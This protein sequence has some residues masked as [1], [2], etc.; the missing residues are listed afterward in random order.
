MAYNLLIAGSGQLGSRYLQGLEKVILPLNIWVSDPSSV[1]LKVAESRWREVTNSHSKHKVKFTRNLEEIPSY[2]DL[3]IVA[4]SADV[5]PM[6][7]GEISK[8]TLTKYWILEKVLGQSDRDLDTMFDCLSGSSA[9][10]VNTHFRTINF[11]NIIRKDLVAHK[12]LLM[13]VYGGSW[14]L[15]CNAIH[16]LDLFSWMNQSSIVSVNTSGLDKVWVGAKR[17]GFW[18][19]FGALEANYSCGGH[20]TLRCSNSSDPVYMTISSGNIKWTID[21]FT[22]VARRFDGFELDATIDLQSERTA[23]LV[24]SILTN[25]V[26]TLPTYLE[27]SLIHRPLINALILHWNK[28]MGKSIQRLPIT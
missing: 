4:T 6:V 9:A 12:P 18:E 20:V 8:K 16:Y 19:I 26:V 27:S 23:A 15:A 28:N 21:E 13:D 22:Q 2:L 17:F 5:R 11:F 1:A 3:A 14:G 25:S 7:V 24:S 10:W